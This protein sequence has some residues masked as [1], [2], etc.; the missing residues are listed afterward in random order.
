MA[1]NNLYGRGISMIA[2][3]TGI[4]VAGCGGGSSDS[5]NTSG[6]SAASSDAPA[7]TVVGSSSTSSGPSSP[8][9]SAVTSTNT[10]DTSIGFAS[11]AAGLISSSIPIVPTAPPGT[12][13]DDASSAA[14]VVAASTSTG[15]SGPKVVKAAISARSGVGMNL[16]S[17][18]SY[19]A[20]VPTIDLMKKASGWITQC[21]D[22]KGTCTGFA[23]GA[24]G[25]DTLEE[26]K[27]DLDADGWVRSLPASTDATLK[28]RTVTTKLAEAGVQ[29][30][31]TYTVVYDGQG[32]ITYGGPVTKVASLSSPGRDV[33]NIVSNSNAVFLSITATSPTNY[34][35]NIRVYLP[36]GACQSDLTVYAADATSCGAGKGD[37]VPFEKFPAGTVWHPA[38]LASV[39]GFRSLRF[40]DWGQTNFTP[41]VAW[42]DR[43]PATARTWFS[44]I[45][46][47]LEAMFDLAATVGADPWMN[48]PAYANDDYVHQFG[49]FAHA[50]L[51]SGSKLAL[52]YGNEMW[53]YQFKPTQWAL[54]QALAMWPNEAK[55]QSNQTPLQL[56]FYALRLVQVCNIVKAE[57]GADA[58][59]VQCVA[60]TQAANSWSTD[61]VL[62]CNYAKV[63]LGKA[64]SNFIDAVAIAPYFGSY[65]GNTASTFAMISSWASDADGGLAKLFQEIT[66]QDSTGAAAVAPLAALGTKVPAGAL[67]QT[68]GWMVATKAVV[69][70]YGIPM[71]A[72]EG[73]QS[74]IPT[75]GSDA[76]VLN[77]MM[78]ANRDPRM[79]Q[80]YATMMSNWQAAGGQ[81]FMLFADAG[82]YSRGGFWGMRE[83]QFATSPKWDWAVKWRDSTACWWAGC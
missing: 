62:Q 59:N 57:F 70:K 77:V 67:A 50:H 43:T 1:F 55:V 12:S 32:T 71:W 37:F 18:N 76:S 56:N 60:N 82:V 10:S 45:G 11:G 34:I 69:A 17:V 29:V 40:M 65:V 38:F 46:V 36:G 27:L 73:G 75:G 52:E 79:A 53:N 24:R 28:Y 5:G 26:A 3:A 64:C 8:T 47:P 14:T 63:I 58:G 25:Y 13:G 78:A 68:Q 6:E 41:A 54:Q 49:K 7:N 30:G 19:S 44:K 61:Q 66:G 48:I 39:K 74:L 21:Q 35:R 15:T 2:M 31:G 33:I 20:E 23:S 42:T 51:A 80:A 16:T 83:N 9:Q 4:F 22:G 72:Y 81:T